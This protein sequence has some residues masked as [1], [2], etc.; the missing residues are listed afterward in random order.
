MP[1]P[2]SNPTDIVTAATAAA[3]DRHARHEWLWA[4]TRAE[5]I[6]AFYRGELTLG[7]CLAWS[8]R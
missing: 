2:H 3:R 6:A 7:D 1:P 4:M 8:G 5:R